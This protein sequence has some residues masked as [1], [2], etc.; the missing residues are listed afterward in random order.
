MNLVFSLEAQHVNM[1]W[2]V[3]F[4]MNTVISGIMKGTNLS[5]DFFGV[6]DLGTSP[7]VCFLYSEQPFF[8]LEHKTLEVK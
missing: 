7:T 4:I 2:F 3:D 8:F 6:C 1:I 5:I